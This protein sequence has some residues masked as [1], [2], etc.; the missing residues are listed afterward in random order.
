MIMIAPFFLFSDRLIESFNPQ[1]LKSIV[2]RYQLV[3]SEAWS[4]STCIECKTN[5]AE[6]F[7]ALGE[8]CIDCWQKKTEPH[9]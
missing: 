9:I 6:V 3:M 7:Q 2:R 5:P 1:V 4:S 8:F